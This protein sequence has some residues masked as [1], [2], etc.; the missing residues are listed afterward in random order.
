M[1]VHVLGPIIDAPNSTFPRTVR[2]RNTTIP[3]TTRKLLW[4]FQKQKKILCL[5]TVLTYILFRRKWKL[6]ES[7]RERDYLH[8]ILNS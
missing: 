8:L 4:I 7:E 3:T 2:T 6:K 1:Y 5:L